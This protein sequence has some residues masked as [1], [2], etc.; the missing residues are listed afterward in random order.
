MAR[1]IVKSP[2][3]KDG[4][5][6]SGYVRYIATRERV[7]ILPD[8]RPPTRKQEQLIG[9]LRK[10][11]PNSPELGEYQSYL[12][13]PTKAN[14]SALISSVLELNW[15][16]V[17]QRDGYAKYIATRPRAEKLGEHGLFGDADHVALETAMRELE[18]YPGNVWTHILSLKRECAERSGFD[19]AAAWR[20]LLRTHRNDIAAAMHIPPSD[21]RWYAAFHNEG[22]HPHVHMIAWSAK[23]GQAYLSKDGIQKIKSTLTNDIFQNEMLHLYEE[24]SL[25]R[26]K[27]VQEARQTMK[28][29][30]HQM[31]IGVC[32]DPAEEKKMLELSQ[33]L[34]NVKGKKTYSYLPKPLKRLKSWM[35]WNTSLRWISAMSS[36]GS[37]SVKSRISIPCRSESGLS[38]PSRKNFGLSKTR[39]SMRLCTFTI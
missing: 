32:S 12:S 16:T 23:P 19:H 20:N 10:D 25:S 17:S 9:K 38:Y 7:E 30:I 21:F 24:K 39:S 31:S 33:A 35:E 1:L 6:I 27:L 37:S 3:L 8:D 4:G 15:T 2:Y 18:A 5:N 13:A 36:G 22:H 14:A 26:D 34:E 28:T 29:L 11:F